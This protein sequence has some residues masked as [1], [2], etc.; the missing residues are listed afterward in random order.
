MPALEEWDPKRGR[1]GR[2]WRELCKTILVPGVCCAWCEFEIDLTLPAYSRWSGTVDH[3]IKLEDGGHPTA[4]WNLQAMHR[5]CN[6]I[7]E[8]KHRAKV[9]LAARAETTIR[10][11]SGLDL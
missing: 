4:R 2:P 8:N 6:T 1:G 3:I 11:V 10:P 9:R 5:R 7:K